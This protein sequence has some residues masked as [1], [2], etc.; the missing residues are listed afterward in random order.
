MNRILFVMIA[1]VGLSSCGQT[2]KPAAVTNSECT[3]FHI[4]HFSVPAI[5]AMDDRDL[6]QLEEQN[7]THRQLCAGDPPPAAVAPACPK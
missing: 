7:K 5:C 1:A 3:D 6:L 4:L 2:V